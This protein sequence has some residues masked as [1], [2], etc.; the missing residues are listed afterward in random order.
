MCKIIKG[1]GRVCYMVTTINIPNKTLPNKTLIL[2]N[3]N[4]QETQ[5]CW[6]I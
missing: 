5:E 1:I 6:T 2:Y 4:V 3:M